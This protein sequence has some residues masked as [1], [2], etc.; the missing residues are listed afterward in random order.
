MLA[1]TSDV[2]CFLVSRKEELIMIIFTPLLQSV[3]MLVPRTIKESSGSQD[4]ISYHCSNLP[5]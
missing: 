4:K 2:C 3:L 1:S 5:C